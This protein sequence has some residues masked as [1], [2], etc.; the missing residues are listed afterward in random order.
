MSQKL[1]R[2][3]QTSLPPKDSE[4]SKLSYQLYFSLSLIYLISSS[5]PTRALPLEP[6]QGSRAN[7]SPGLRHPTST[8]RRAPPASPPMLSCPESLSHGRAGPRALRDQSRASLI[9]EKMWPREPGCHVP[10]SRVRPGELYPLLRRLPG[11][12]PVP[13]TTLSAPL[14]AQDPERVSDGSTRLSA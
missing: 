1:P 9:N 4:C 7:L 13:Y 3:Q 10:S 12:P 14:G 6:T 11:S 8:S 5:S 2:L